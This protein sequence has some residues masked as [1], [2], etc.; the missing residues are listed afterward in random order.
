MGGLRL[1]I[2]DAA[3]AG[4]D[5]GPAIPDQVALIGDWI[6]QGAAYQGH[7]AFER[8]ERPVVP[9]VDGAI[10]PIDSFIRHRLKQ[11]G[12]VPSPPASRETL[13]RRV[14]LDLIG[15]PPTLNEIDSFVADT[16]PDAYEKVVDR[17]LA[18]PHYGEQMAQQWL[19]FARYA[20]SNGFQVDSSRQPA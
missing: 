6:K 14:T 5:S 20:D 12:L 4:G 7:W 13:L 18:S 1:D 11:E 3:M 10:H 9:A 19:D 15:L 16:S 8:V 17:L 2:A